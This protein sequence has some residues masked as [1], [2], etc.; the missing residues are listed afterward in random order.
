MQKRSIT[1]ILKSRPKRTVY[2]ELES[3]PDGECLVVKRFHA[4]G[5]G[6]GLRD[7]LRAHRE[8]HGLR[9]WKALGLP[10]PTPV[11]VRHRAGHWE[12]VMEGIRGARTLPDFLTQERADPGRT[13][14]VAMAVG[15][16]LA[17]L[18]RSG[19]HH[20]D[21]HPGNLLIDSQDGPWL[22]DPTPQPLF[23]S[24]ALPGR[25]R[26][27]RLC[28]QL[29]EI[30]T[31]L[32]RAQIAAAYR[33]ADGPAPPPN[34][35]QER[36]RIE[37]DARL[38]RHDEAKAR[39]KRWLRTSGSTQVE[40][41][42]IHRLS[43][44]DGEG[45]RIAFP[46]TGTAKTTWLTFARFH[47]HRIPSLQAKRLE[48]SPEC[49]IEALHAPGVSGIAAASH[50]TS[51]ARLLG[52][53]HDR[54][55]P[56]GSLA[57]ENFWTEDSGAIC[58]NPAKTDLPDL[59]ATHWNTPNFPQWVPTFDSDFIRAFVGEFGGTQQQAKALGETLRGR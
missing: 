28:G 32:F 12:L 17:K 59:P 3:K 2:R 26:W 39:I 40:G 45:T 14:G 52:K 57:V 29:R 7:G 48:L 31:P 25:Q 11:S 58:I 46:D 42:H 19:A 27:V 55:L 33:K 24:R 50:P 5:F 1:N 21:P 44:P 18:D 16:L 37:E 36:Q 35:E 51:L 43:P 13:R 30:S 9:R 22:I 4:P 47:E 10:A 41:S 38:W 8:A 53:L 15:Q 6:Q 20:G 56:I 34:S 23:S 49:A 54:G